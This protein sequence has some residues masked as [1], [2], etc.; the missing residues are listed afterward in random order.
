MIRSAIVPTPLD[1]RKKNTLK[2]KI[3][4]SLRFLSLRGP[5][6]DRFQGR[7]AARTTHRN[8]AHILMAYLVMA[9]LV[10]ACIV[11]AYTLE[12][13]TRQDSYRL[14]SHGGI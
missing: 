9:Y 10:M 1:I 8:T 3:S 7:G 4:A 5:S 14:Y 2:L 6:V 13:R 11:V 12:Q